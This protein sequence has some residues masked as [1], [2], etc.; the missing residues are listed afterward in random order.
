[1]WLEIFS[2]ELFFAVALSTENSACGGERFFQLTTRLDGQ[3]KPTKPI[4]G[5]L[6]EFLCSIGNSDGR[7]SALHEANVMS[8][9]K[10]WPKHGQLQVFS[11]S[12]FRKRKKTLGNSFLSV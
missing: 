10:N 1:M 2:I 4:F 7:F 9:E 5:F 11:V 8:S 12:W 6:S 3:V